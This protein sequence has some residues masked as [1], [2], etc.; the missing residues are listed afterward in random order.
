M[1]GGFIGAKIN[2]S[3]NYSSDS[4]A[5]LFSVDNNTLCVQNTNQTYALYFMSNYGP[6]WGGNHDLY[7]ADNCGNNSDSYSQL[8]HT[9]RALESGV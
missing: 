1:F 9:Y 6:T 3:G 8:N 5:F 7:L 4:K 2:S